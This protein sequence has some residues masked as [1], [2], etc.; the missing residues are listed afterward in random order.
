MAHDT[1]HDAPSDDVLDERPDT[2]AGERATNPDG[3]PRNRLVAVI[4]GSAYSESV[5]DHAAWFARRANASI[6]VVHVIG[7]RQGL[8]DESNLSGNIG[9]G[10]RTALLAELAE[11]DAQRAKL[12]Q[13]RGRAILL[14]AEARLTAA[15]ADSVRT[16]LRHGEIVESVRL[17]EKEADL[18]VLGKRGEAADFDTMHLGSNLERVVRST[19]KPVLVAAR[20]FREPKRFLVAFDGARSAVQAIDFITER[21]H[22]NDLPCHLV[23]VGTD[24]A[25]TRRPLEGAAAQLREAGF[26]VETEIRP[27]QPESAIARAVEEHAIDLL[28]IGAY[29]HSRIRSMIIGSTTSALLASCK[30]PVLLFR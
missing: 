26:T 17:L 29:G 30:V 9:L 1:P 12:G 25:A 23:T 5:C 4:D 2:G 16:R 10:A 24:N 14:D 22:Y 7:R 20:A 8:G 6:D 27:G 3:S 19:H 15:G 11:L 21:P 18:L 13:K 28:V